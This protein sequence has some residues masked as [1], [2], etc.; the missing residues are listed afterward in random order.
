MIFEVSAGK[1]DCN[2]IVLPAIEISA[3]LKS[4]VSY[5]DVPLAFAVVIASL[6]VAGPLSALEVTIIVP[7]LPLFNRKKEKISRQRS[8]GFINFRGQ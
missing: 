3:I 6:K 1:E 4:I 5:D 2:M 7:A 8:F